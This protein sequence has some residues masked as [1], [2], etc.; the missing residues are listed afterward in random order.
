MTASQLRIGKARTPRNAR[1]RPY[2]I[3][4]VVTGVFAAMLIGAILVSGAEGPGAAAA[5]TAAASPDGTQPSS[6]ATGPVVPAQPVATNT[7]SESPR[8]SVDSHAIISYLGQLI[9]WYRHLD[10][11]ERLATEPAETLY[12]SDDRQNANR[13]VDLGF[14]YADA[15]AKLIEQ[16]SP[17]TGGPGQTGAPLPGT[18]SGSSSVNNP[19]SELG[20]L[21]SDRNEAQAAV[22]AAKVRVSGLEQ[23]LSRARGAQRDSLTHLLATAR[24]E[25]TLA[26]SRVDSIAAM[27]DFET[28]TGGADGSATGLEAQIAQLEAS[29]RPPSVEGKSTQQPLTANLVAASAGANRP[30]TSATGI[31]GQASNLIALTQKRQ[32]LATTIDL[33]N[34]VL[35][36]GEQLRAPLVEE[37]RR[38]NEQA[39]ALATHRSSNDL[40]TIKNIQRQAEALTRRHQMLVDALLPLSK[41]AVALNQYVANLERWRG[42][43]DQRFKADLRSLLV[44]L[45]GLLMLLL[46]VVLG[47]ALWRRLTFRYVQDLQRRHQLLQFSRIVVVAIIA[48][49]LLFDFANELGALA[50]VMG[51]AA[52]GIALTLQNVILSLAGY[53]YLS[54]RYGI[55]VGDRVQISGISGDVLEIGLFKMT[56]MELGSDDAGRQPTGRV[57]VFPNSVVFQPNGNFF[58]QLPGSS[59]VWNELRLS[60]AP[61]CDYRLAERR[62]IEVVTE[63]FARYRDTIQRE[64]R[65]LER[66]LN[67]RIEMPRPQS[68]LVLGN[69]GIEIVLRYPV[70]LKGATQTSDEIARR[71]VDAIKREPG[72]R[73]VPQGTPAIQPEV[74]HDAAGHPGEATSNGGAKSAP[75]SPLIDNREAGMAAAAGAGATVAEAFTDAAATEQSREGVGSLALPSA[76]P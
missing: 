24:A 16:G 25:L 60:L 67:L 50:T 51:F 28:A 38:I 22:D 54:G 30:D 42:L 12:V 13:A 68:R 10:V 74:A 43:V 62:L 9:G 72:L 40:A 20:K 63:V 19:T 17:T 37:I 56:L 57:V 46:A 65:G 6:L 71:L 4:A 70:Q 39:L 75:V 14:E 33:T 18:P 55:R 2:A 15:A 31:I 34:Q 3:G 32:A 53:F 5:S 11:E 8:P 45:G 49:V 52:A 36:T 23:Q 69:A 58:K 35:A 59:F 64:Y 1:R 21:T 76:K 48:L 61:D 47:A 73:L 27:I 7:S 26:Q 41:Q 29:V 44:R 66:E